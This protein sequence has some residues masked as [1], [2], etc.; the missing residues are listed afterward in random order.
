[1]CNAISKYCAACSVRRPMQTTPSTLS[2][3]PW[4]EAD[5]CINDLQLLSLSEGQIFAGP[6]LVVKEGYVDGALQL[7]SQG[8]NHRQLL[9]PCTSDS[10]SGPCRLCL[11]PSLT[12][13]QL[14]T[15]VEHLKPSS[16]SLSPSLSFSTCGTYFPMF[17]VPAAATAVLGVYG[18]SVTGGGW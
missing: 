11:P 8:V 6:L 16:L 7:K 3:F 12:E 4:N 14:Q 1:M 2:L 5:L 9:V 13:Q 18:G 17:D 10:G 15:S